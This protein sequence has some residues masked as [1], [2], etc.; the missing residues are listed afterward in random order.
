[1]CKMETCDISLVKEEIVEP[2]KT[3]PQNEDEFEIK[4][5]DPNLVGDFT[6]TI[7]YEAQRFQIS[8][9][10]R[11]SPWD[12]FL[13]IKEQIKDETDTSNSVNEIVKTE[14][15]LYDSS[16]G[17]MDSNIDHFTPV[18]K[19]E[20]VKP[21]T[22]SVLYAIKFLDDARKS[23]T[24]HTIA[25]CF[26]KAQLTHTNLPD[27]D[28]NDDDD[29]DDDERDK[30]NSIKG[31]AKRRANRNN[32]AIRVLSLAVASGVTGL[33]HDDGD[34]VFRHVWVGVGKRSARVFQQRE[35][36]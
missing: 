36:R 1:M 2:I 31:H 10:E 16:L 29:D 3:E 7:N 17:I 20:T 6:D 19:S 5:E 30:E 24:Q 21:V 18:D 25:K 34:V 23:V 22:I 26:S 27:Y 4:T 11:K 12:G 28:I 13:P 9:V 8:D 14:Q 32:C 15:K 33:C 35:S